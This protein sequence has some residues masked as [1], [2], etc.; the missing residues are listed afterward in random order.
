MQT[1]QVFEARLARAGRTWILL[2][3]ITYKQYEQ[4]KKFTL[5]LRAKK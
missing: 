1:L 5:L 2:K 3:I 4:H